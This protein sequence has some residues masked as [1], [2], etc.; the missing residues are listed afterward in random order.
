VVIN[1]LLGSGSM[2]FGSNSPSARPE[3]N[4]KTMPQTEMLNAAW[5]ERLTTDRSVSVPVS[6]SRSK[7]PSA[8]PR[9]SSPFTRRST[10]TGLASQ[11]VPGSKC[12]AGTGDQFAHY[13]RWPIP[14]AALS[15]FARQSNPVG[16]D[17]QAAQITSSVAVMIT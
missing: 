13:R 4:G 1:F 2:V 14:S 3:M 12:Q 7:M 6:S 15:A 17:D 8:P 10:E 5:R 11:R 16:D 9:R